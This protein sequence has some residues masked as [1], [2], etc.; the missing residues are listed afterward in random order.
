M[1]NILTLIVLLLFIMALSR[2]LQTNP[3]LLT[4]LPELNMIHGVNLVT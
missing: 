4:S 1:P 3:K 2:N